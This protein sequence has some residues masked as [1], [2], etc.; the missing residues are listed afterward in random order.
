MA[1]QG[2]EHSDTAFSWH[3]SQLRNA[4]KLRLETMAG[5]TGGPP[6][7]QLKGTENRICPR[8]CQ[9]EDEWGRGKAPRPARLSRSKPQGHCSS[10]KGQHTLSSSCIPKR[11]RR[12][13]GRP[14]PAILARHHQAGL[15]DHESQWQNAQ[16]L[17]LRSEKPYFPQEFG[18]EGWKS[19]T[20]SSLGD[21]FAYLNKADIIFSRARH[22]HP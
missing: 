7:H 1:Y 6:A 17:T 10:H 3:V 9:G 2:A 8:C 16:G 20:S 19:P 22:H 14:Q 4:H 15:Q 21:K 13:V 5:T 12:H 18:F 11:G